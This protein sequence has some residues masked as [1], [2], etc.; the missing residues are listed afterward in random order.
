ML[1][2]GEPHATLACSETPTAV[3]LAGQ[4]SQKHLRQSSRVAA[5]SPARGARTEKTQ[6]T[7]Q[8]LKWHD[9]LGPSAAT[10]TL[11]ATPSPLLK[12][13]TLHTFF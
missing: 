1:R 5:C 8:E 2:A 11:P 6:Q 4:H 10:C 13:Y 12:H 9:D 3:T 7:A